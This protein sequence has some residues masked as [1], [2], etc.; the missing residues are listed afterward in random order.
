MVEG[1]RVKTLPRLTDRWSA[2]A[3]VV[4]TRSSSFSLSQICELFVVHG[5]RLVRLHNASKSGSASASIS[6]WRIADIPIEQFTCC[7]D[8]GWVVSIPASFTCCTSSDNL[9]KLRSRQL[10]KP[11]DRE[12]FRDHGI[13]KLGI[14]W[15]GGYLRRSLN[16][17]QQAFGS[18]MIYLV[19]RHMDSEHVCHT[20]FN[21]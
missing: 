12:Q 11:L 17:R 9:A 16:Y 14:C 10:V 13:G 7:N 15:M 5:G 21:P 19:R 20:S 8:F 2:L 18:L 1:P 6:S 3:L 4:S